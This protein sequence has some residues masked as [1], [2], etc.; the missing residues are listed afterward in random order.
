M[1]LNDDEFEPFSIVPGF[2]PV[3]RFFAQ[4][5][6]VLMLNRV[7]LGDCVFIWEFFLNIK[8]INEKKQ[9]SSTG[10]CGM[11]IVLSW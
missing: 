5:D 7:E 3:G 10:C 6:D 9:N 8:W 4:L 11:H 2:N 1:L